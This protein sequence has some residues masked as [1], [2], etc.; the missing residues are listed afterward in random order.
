VCAPVEA[1]Q[2]L[3]AVHARH[4]EVQQNE[5]RAERRRQLEC[6]EPVVRDAGHVDSAV[7]GERSAHRQREVVV[8]VHDEDTD[9]I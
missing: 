8:I 6:L 3:V 9:T 5:V 4:L 2:G 7:S 1:S